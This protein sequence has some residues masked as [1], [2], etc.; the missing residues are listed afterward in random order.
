[1][2]ALLLFQDNQLQQMLTLLAEEKALLQGRTHHHLARVADDKAE[3]A[4]RLEEVDNRIANHPGL[5]EPQWQEKLQAM[6]QLA[7]ECSHANAVNG[8]MIEQLRARQG[9]QS[10]LMLRLLGRSTRTY[11]AKGKASSKTRLLTDLRA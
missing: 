9:D 1:M 3:L 2:D 6:K 10:E 7:R 11:D 8:E 5:H 4:M